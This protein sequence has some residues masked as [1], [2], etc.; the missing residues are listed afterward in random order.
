MRVGDQE[1]RIPTSMVGNYPNPRRWDAGP[2]GSG[3]GPGPTGIVQPGG[4]PGRHGRAGLRPGDAGLD[5][6]TDGRL[7]GDNYA[8]QAA[9]LLLPRLGYDLKG[10]YLGFPIYSRLHAAPRPR[11]QAARRD[12]GGAGPGAE[13]GDR[14]A[15]QGAVHRHPGARPGTN[16]LHYDDPRDRRWP[17]PPRSTRTSSRSTRWASTSSSSTSS[18]GPTSTRTGRSRRSTAPSRASS[19]RRSSCTS[20][21][22][23]GRTPANMP[24]DTA[25]AGRSS[26]SPSAGARPRGHRDGVPNPTRRT[27]TSSTWRTAG[28]APTTCW[29]DVLKNHP[30]P[31]T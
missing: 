20:L 3:R 19:T 16:D 23:L 2:D 29:L 14:Q 22:Q 12:H 8:D 5:I 25:Q 21:G 4:L 26:T 1:V 30:L 18:P 9:L 6:I 28:A 7:H 11:D 10:G 17:S 13:A 15:D 27:S 31:E 24:D